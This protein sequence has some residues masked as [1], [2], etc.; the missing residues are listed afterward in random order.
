MRTRRS[1]YRE[2]SVDGMK[3]GPGCEMLE[4]IGSCLWSEGIDMARWCWV[5]GVLIRFEDI[6]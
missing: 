2:D 3:M 1:G 5:W 6:S 4:D